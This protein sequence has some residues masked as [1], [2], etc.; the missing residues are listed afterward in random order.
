MI[1]R[2]GDL[3]SIPLTIMIHSL[4]RPFRF[5]AVLAALLV[6]LSVSNLG[7]AEA[8]TAEGLDNLGSV[9]VPPGIDAA[10]VKAVILHDL[11]RHRWVVQSAD[12]STIVANLNYKGYAATVTFHYNTDRIDLEGAIYHLDD[13]GA[14]AG[15]ALWTDRHPRRWLA[16]LKNDIP[17]FFAGAK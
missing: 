5:A 11:S 10:R 12:N 14:R 1:P 8:Q 13:S 16:Y 9:A 7:R 2:I 6:G 17:K 3:L 4:S 15:R